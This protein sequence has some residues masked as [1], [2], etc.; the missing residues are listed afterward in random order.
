MD[1]SKT[2]RHAHDFIRPLPK[3]RGR[4][5]SL[6]SRY[7][8]LWDK[9]LLRPRYNEGTAYSVTQDIIDL[10]RRPP[11]APNK[12]HLT[13]KETA[14]EEI[15]RHNDER[16]KVASR[17]EQDAIE[18][19]SELFTRPSRACL[20]PDL[21]YKT[22]RD[23][24]A[25]FFKAQLL[26]NV[27]VKWV[28]AVIK[29]WVYG[30]TEL[31]CAG[32][33]RIIMDANTI[34]S[35]EITDVYLQMFRTLLHEMVVIIPD[36]LD[37]SKIFQFPLIHFSILMIACVHSHP[38]FKNQKRR[39]KGLRRTLRTVRGMRPRTPLSDYNT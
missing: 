2:Y 33:A 1:Q 8:K 9:A 24:D 31:T 17:L 12:N 7:H 15:V 16:R 39:Q 20:G 26:G 13:S 25:V 6:N 19:L 5:S 28:P 35:E 22:F 21:I 29:W 10:T 14:T 23:F 11:M 37:K 18:R 4:G 30:Y 27:K 3:R 38:Y 34:F 32:K 36:F